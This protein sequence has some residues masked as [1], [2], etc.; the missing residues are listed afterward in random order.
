VWNNVKVEE[1]PLKAYWEQHKS[2]YTW[3]Q[4]V[5]FSEIFITSDSLGQVLRDSLDNGADFGELAGRHTQRSGYKK[6]LGDWGLQPVDANELTGKANGAEIG[7]TERPNKFQYGFSIIKTTEKDQAREKTFEEAHSEVS[8]KFQEFESKR[9]E[10]EW[11][12]RLRDKFG[13]EVFDDV[14]SRAFSSLGK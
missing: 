6:K 10:R 11:I 5:R 3:P 2:E 9:I 1:E 12:D 7:W 14:F 4:R 13:V 8:S